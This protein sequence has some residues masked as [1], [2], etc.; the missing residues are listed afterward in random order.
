[1]TSKPISK[2]SYTAYGFEANLCAEVVRAVKDY[3]IKGESATIFIL[4][5]DGNVMAGGSYDKDGMQRHVFRL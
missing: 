4:L 1:M 5:Q 2:E 3:R